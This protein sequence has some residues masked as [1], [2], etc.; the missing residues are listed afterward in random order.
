M[1]REMD[2]KINQVKI[3]YVEDDIYQAEV[4]SL[5]L[6]PDYDVTHFSDGEEFLNSITANQFDLLI[7][8]WELPGMSGLEIVRQFRERFGFSV[9]VL[10]ATQKDEELSIVA[11]LNAGAD[12]Y[13][14]KPIKE[15]ELKARLLAL[16]RRNKKPLPHSLVIEVGNIKLYLD[17]E[18]AELNGQSVELTHKE[19]MVAKVL[20][21]N[22]NT[23]VTRDQLLQ[24][25]WDTN[26][27]INTRTV[28]VHVSK[29]RRLFN[30]NPLMGYHIKTIYNHGYRFE[31]VDA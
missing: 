30:I 16:V 10:F 26:V 6:K 12:D 3:G 1:D 24:K 14:I 27:E 31:K 17:K 11:A 4:I 7:F 8:D 25:V 19:Y 15:Q 20:F 21:E 18:V 9:P 2:R 5:W 22:Q 29:V 13:M 28:D 23:I